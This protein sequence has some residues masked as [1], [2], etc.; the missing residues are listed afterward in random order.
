MGGG[1]DSTPKRDFGAET[2]G[3]IKQQQAAGQGQID[4]ARALVRLY[5]K[6]AKKERE[7][8]TNQREQ[9][10]KDLLG[11]GP[12]YNEAFRGASPSY[13]AGEDLLTSE[14]LSAE[15]SPLLDELNRQAIAAG[16]GELRMELERQALTELGLGR[17]LSP[18]QIRAVEQASREAGS[19]RGTLYSPGSIADEVLAR[20]AAGT[21]RESQR[22]GFAG[23]VA[24][25]GLA[26]DASNRNFMTSVE[27]GNQAD[28]G[29]RRN[30]A[31]TAMQVGGNSPV[32]GLFGQRSAT[33]IT[34]PAAYLGATSAAVQPA[35]AYGSDLYNTNFNAQA[36]SQNKASPWIGAASGA[37]TGATLGT[38]VNPGIG[39]A[40][41]AV[42]GGA[43]GY[44][45][46]NCWVARAIFGAGDPRWCWFRL[47]LLTRAPR[48]F[49]L[50]YNIA[51]PAF[52]K[53][54]A[55]RPLVRAMLLPW[56]QAKV[57]V[58]FNTA[59]PDDAEQVR[60]WFW[61]YH[62]LTRR[63]LAQIKEG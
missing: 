9:D 38:A 7:A 6:L 26:E 52:A 53:W 56:F 39:T 43:V 20:D 33:P 45:A 54:L 40:V 34:A 13:A 36:S 14:T 60:R 47:W 28:T 32:L 55:P 35:W 3:I 59:G 37:A 17:R 57:V 22:R 8:T 30:F 19:A 12:G 44:F 27:T 24:Q 48:W 15:R 62:E 16:P 51:G 5:P 25:L 11:L 23:N 21:L 41:G 63:H 1:G 61:E 31:A 42:A 50:L 2:A 49:R 4:L 29:N 10:V 18:E 46:G 58:I